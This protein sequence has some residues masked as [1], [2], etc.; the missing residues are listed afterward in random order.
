MA[1]SEIDM[2][3]EKRNSTPTL[4]RGTTQRDDTPS[5][6]AAKMV[7]LL[8]VVTCTEVQASR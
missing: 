8:V 7:H 6:V 3:N 1:Y 4:V 5:S 2:E